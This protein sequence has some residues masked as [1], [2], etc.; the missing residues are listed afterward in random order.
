MSTKTVPMFNP[1]TGKTA[2]V[3]PNEVDTMQ[4]VGW[5]IDEKAKAVVSDEGIGTDSGDQFSDD[6][7]REAIEKAT[8]EKPHHRLGREKLVERFNELN[9]EAAKG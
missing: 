7:L 4:V 6:Q 5:R 8:G 2:D 3:H 1:D 9:A